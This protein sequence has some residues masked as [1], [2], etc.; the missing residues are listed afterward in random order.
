MGATGLSAGAGWF[1]GVCPLA[2][3]TPTVTVQFPFIF[4]SMSTNWGSELIDCQLSDFFER[5][6]ES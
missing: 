3:L 5:A 6:L 2:L 4:P 1:C